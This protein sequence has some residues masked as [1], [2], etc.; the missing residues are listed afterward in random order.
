MRKALSLITTL[1]MVVSLTTSI[2]A[3]TTTTAN[4]VKLY[5]TKN[6]WFVDI[7]AAGTVTVK[8]NKTE[9]NFSFDEAGTYSIGLQKGYTGQLK[10]INFEEVPVVIE[11]VEQDYF[12][13]YMDDD[14]VYM[15]WTAVKWN[16]IIPVP[17]N[18]VKDGCVFEGWKTQSGVEVTPGMTYAQL[19]NGNDTVTSESIWAQWHKHEYAAVV[20][21]PTC[22]KEGFTTYT[23]SCG[24]EYIDDYVDALGHMEVLD[25]NAEIVNSEWNGENGSDARFD[26]TLKLAFSMSRDGDIIEEVVFVDAYYRN[27]NFNNLGETFNYIVGCYDVSINVI[28]DAQNSNQNAD[29]SI[30]SVSVVDSDLVCVD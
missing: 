3:S 11:P 9:F 17:E 15:Y 12:V 19:V 21:A 7:A 26:L 28:L 2:F 10:F 16:D 27:S 30:A 13:A 4:D 29:F 8:D 22:T 5:S 25:V 1:A 24:D 14:N 6:E 23:C 18:P 20:T